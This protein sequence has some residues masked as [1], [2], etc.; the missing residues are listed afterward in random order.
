MNT[1]LYCQIGTAIVQKQAEIIGLNMALAKA[2]AVPGMLVDGLGN[3]LKYNTD[4]VDLLHLLI[5]QYMNLSG[6]AAIIF[7]KEAVKDIVAKHTDLS[8]PAELKET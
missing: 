5:R 6:E 1:D 3:V 2:N 8:L 7:S 4:P